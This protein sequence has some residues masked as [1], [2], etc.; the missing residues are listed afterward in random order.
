ME[1]KGRKGEGQRGRWVKRDSKKARA[2]PMDQ[3]W[4]LSYLSIKSYVEV[5]REKLGL[6][7]YREVRGEEDEGTMPVDLKWFPG[8]GEWQGG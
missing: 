3:K 4:P 2:K 7:G 8:E 1:G 5:E 6:R